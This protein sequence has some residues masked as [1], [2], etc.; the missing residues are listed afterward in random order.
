[1]PGLVGGAP[2]P[3]HTPVRV[4]TGVPSAKQ[5][6]FVNRLQSLG[7][8]A[9]ARHRAECS[10]C[11]RRLFSLP[12]SAPR[13]EPQRRR[14]A[15]ERPARKAFRCLEP[16]QR[17]PACRP[18]PPLTSS[19]FGSGSRSPGS[20]NPS[21]STSPFHCRCGA[22]GAELGLRPGSKNRRLPSCKLLARRGRPQA[23]GLGGLTR[24]SPASDPAG[25]RA[26][27]LAARLGPR[28]SRAVL[29][30]SPGPRPT[31]GASQPPPPKCPGRARRAPEPQ[32]WGAGIGTGVGCCA[33][34]C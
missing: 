19:C 20:R 33:C 9:G 6:F 25:S 32:L 30:P 14:P 2:G 28:E 7:G 29:L 27:S 17:G 24:G 31:L 16:S 8:E 1:M 18:P 12:A 3:C 23:R 15:E 26:V 10:C 4:K 5:S 34:C 21:S 22:A 11:G 13:P